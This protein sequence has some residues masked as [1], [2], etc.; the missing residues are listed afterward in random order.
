VPAV[1]R[2][3]SSEPR[4]L[5]QLRRERVPVSQVQVSEQACCGSMKPADHF[6]FVWNPVFTWK[7]RFYN[8]KLKLFFFLNRDKLRLGA[9]PVYDETRFIGA[10]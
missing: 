6:F 10:R 4:R 5:R 9:L 2:L 1:L 3:R 7:S 8:N